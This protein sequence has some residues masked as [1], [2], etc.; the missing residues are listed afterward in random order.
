[1]ASLLKVKDSNGNII[2]IPAIKGKSA[3]QSAVD[4][5]YKGTEEEFNSLLANIGC[6]IER[7]TKTTEPV[8]LRGVITLNIPLTGGFTVENSWGLL[9]ETPVGKE[10]VSIEFRTAPDGDWVDIRNMHA[11]DNNPFIL[12]MSRVYD[13][14][15]MTAFAI[16][17]PVD[18]NTTNYIYNAVN[19]NLDDCY[20]RITYYND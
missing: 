18:T 5:G 16:V 2:D 6:P 4:G 20:A 8:D 9:P 7:P 19:E 11:V 1:M 14:N 13:R 15:G 3:Y 17:C 12:D 10:I